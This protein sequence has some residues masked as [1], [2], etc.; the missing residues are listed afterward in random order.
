MSFSRA[1]T[2]ERTPGSGRPPAQA[3][4]GDQL[5]APPIERMLLTIEDAGTVLGVRRSTIYALCGKGQLE[6]R[7]IGTRTLVTTA[8]IRAFVDT[9]SAA[10]IAAPKST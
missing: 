6:T 7:K 5:S 10:D 9:L 8:S 4:V 3:G 2:S 1:T